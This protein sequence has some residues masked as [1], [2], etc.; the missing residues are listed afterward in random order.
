MNMG[1]VESE[2]APIEIFLSSDDSELLMK[3]ARRLKAAIL[4]MKGAKDPTI[5]T[6]DI[7]PE[8]RIELD[9]TKMGQLGLPIAVI[10]MQLQNALTGNDD[11]QFDVKGQEY[12]IRIMMDKFDRKNVDDIKSLT[13]TPN[14]IA[15]QNQINMT[16]AITNGTYLDS[17]VILAVVLGTNSGS[18]Y[19][20]VDFSCSKIGMITE[21]FTAEYNLL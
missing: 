2:E 16:E 4:D 21:N 19:N 1:M 15:I 9:R 7:T 10:G 20:A 14:S 11:S 8:V 12:D 17:D 6:D 13:F 3:E 18:A 5:S